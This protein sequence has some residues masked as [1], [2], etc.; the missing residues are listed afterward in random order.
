MMPALTSRPQPPLRISIVIIRDFK[1]KKK[2]AMPNSRTP[3]SDLPFW[4]LD[5]GVS[6]PY[7]PPKSSAKL[8]TIFDMTKKKCENFFALIDK[9]YCQTTMPL[10]QRICIVNPIDNRPIGRNNCAQKILIRMDGRVTANQPQR[11]TRLFDDIKEIG[12]A[13]GVAVRKGHIISECIRTYSVVWD[14]V[15]KSPRKVILTSNYITS[16]VGGRNTIDYYACVKTDFAAKTLRPK[17]RTYPAFDMRRLAM[18]S[19]PSLAM[20]SARYRAASLVRT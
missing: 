10:R 13:I 1:V 6:R 14:L 20:V 3:L 11:R 15:E 8:R 18:M 19:T 12:I 16:V 9:R 7:L 4:A 2:R 17:P 5:R